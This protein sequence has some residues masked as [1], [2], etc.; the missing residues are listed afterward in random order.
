[1]DQ[2]VA[3]LVRGQP[4][5]VVGRAEAD[6]LIVD[7]QKGRSGTA[8]PFNTMASH[9]ALR[10]ARAKCDDDSASLKRPVRGDRATTAYFADVVN[11]VPTKGLK[12]IIRGA[13]A[14]SGSM[15]VGL[16]RCSR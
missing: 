16:S 12:Q 11:G 4:P 1:L 7:D 15:P 9:P 3:G 6:S 5:Q 14:A 13:S 8:P 10:P 2:P